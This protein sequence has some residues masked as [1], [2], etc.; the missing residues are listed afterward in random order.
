MKRYLKNFELTE[1][2]VRKSVFDCLA[3]SPTRKARWKEDKTIFFLAEYLQKWERQHNFQEISDIKVIF[4]R[5]KYYTINDK[6]RLFPLVNFIAHEMFLEI[7]N[8]NIV[9]R[10][11]NYNTIIDGSSKKVR[12]IGS[13]SMKQQC[14]D[15][16]VVNAL[17]EMFD[18]KIGK[19]QC[20][21][22]P[23]KDQ[24]FGKQAL[25]TWIRTNPKKCQWLFKADVQQFYPS[26]GHHILWKLL[27][28]DIKNQD[29]LY[30]AFVLIKSYGEIGLCIGSFFCQY[31]ANY[32]MSYV[33][34]YISEMLY[35]V[36]RGKRSNLV[37][38]VLF[39]MDDI[40]LLGSNKKHVKK[41]AIE[42]EKY[43]NNFLELKLKL[44]YQLFPLDS[45]PL[46]MM[47]YK[48]YSDHTTVRKR[49]FVKANKVFIKVKG[50]DTM[51]LEDAH[52]VVSYYGYFKYTNSVK[53]R[54]KVKMMNSLRVAKEVISN[55]AKKCNVS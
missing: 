20:A 3:G 32:V 40:I 41:A 16:V 11:I 6:E 12:K 15:Y 49:I 52:K 23:N 34:H 29:I 37:H 8:R 33:Y 39:Y 26:I 54:K 55:E 22:L 24:L 51:S 50:K 1:E 46:D 53:Y 30:L 18:A 10:K 27:P 14:Y 36:R 13:A 48:I 35:T 38:H 28:R 47:G 19:Y 25:E 4:K 17:K 31:L 5:I 7:K 43:L 45:R 9:L 21:S 42:L 44:N 2:F